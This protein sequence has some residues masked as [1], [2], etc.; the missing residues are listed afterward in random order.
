MQGHQ[1]AVLDLVAERRQPEGITAWAATDIRD[2]SGRRREAARHDF[3][4]SDVL[5]LATA[6]AQPVALF[7]AL[8]IRPYRCLLRVHGIRR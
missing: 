2:D 7:P 6:V 8:V 4:R 3:G 5:K 1:V